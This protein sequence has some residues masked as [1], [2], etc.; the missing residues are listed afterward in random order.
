[1][2]TVELQILALSIVL[3]FV[4]IVLASHAK[5]WQYGY[6]WSASARDEPRPPLTGAAG[7][8]ER[9]AANFGETFPFF[10]AAVLVAHVT[11]RHNALT[12]WGVQLY[13]W[14]RVV[15]LPAYAFGIPL[16]RS[17]IWNVSVAG[18]ALLLIALL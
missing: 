9:A 4:H 14:A 15:Y 6:R 7:R 13:F 3:G 17:I 1:M 18:I 2:M 12:F 5:S 16:V 8:L 10:A 11:G